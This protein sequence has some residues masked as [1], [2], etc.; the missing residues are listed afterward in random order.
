MLPTFFIPQL[1]ILCYAFPYPFFFFLNCCLLVHTHITFLT[2]TLCT[3]HQRSR[4]FSPSLPTYPPSDLLLAS[5]LDSFHLSLF[6][7]SLF[8]F[9]FTKP[10]MT[11][12]RTFCIFVYQNLLKSCSSS[13]FFPTL[14]SSEYR[15]LISN[16]IL[17]LPPP[18][19]SSSPYPPPLHIPTS[20]HIHISSLS[21]SVAAIALVDD[22]DDEDNDDSYR[23]Y[24]DTA[25]ATTAACCCIASLTSFF[26]SFFSSFFGVSLF[27]CLF[28]TL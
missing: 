26:P 9:E 12:P 7:F 24:H 11:P 16:Y 20:L 3:S 22:D 25:A 4:T 28:F 17:L 18:S 2:L 15:F 23:Y 13:S 10:L 1:F 6:H 19:P 8:F 27:V 5:P 21:P 14:Y